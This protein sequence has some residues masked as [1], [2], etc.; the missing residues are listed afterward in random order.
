MFVI[1]CVQAILNYTE[2][3]WMTICNRFLSSMYL[4][5]N[6]D[7]YDLIIPSSYTSQVCGKNRINNN[8]SNNNN[9]NNNNNYNKQVFNLKFSL[10]LYCW[11]VSTGWIVTLSLMLDHIRQARNRTIVKPKLCWHCGIHY[12]HE[13]LPLTA[14]DTYFQYTCLCQHKSQQQRHCHIPLL[15]IHL[16][17]RYQ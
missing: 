15:Y 17:L 8:N 4:K 12:L 13:I 9:N 6:S 11:I 7:M 5:G 3:M 1:V 14:L 2:Y 10:Y 16:L